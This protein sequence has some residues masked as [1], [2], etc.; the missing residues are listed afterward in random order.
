MLDDLLLRPQIHP[1]GDWGEARHPSK[2]K[3]SAPLGLAARQ[4]VRCRNL[5]S[6]L[7]FVTEGQPQTAPE[8]GTL[9][10]ARGRS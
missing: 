7:G 5:G 4:Q 3:I 2:T 8:D 9:T 6:H 1:T 10:F